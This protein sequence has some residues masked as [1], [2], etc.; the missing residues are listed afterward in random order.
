MAH[1]SVGHPVEIHSAST[2]EAAV[3]WMARIYG[4]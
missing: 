2:Y 3:T 1:R 4:P